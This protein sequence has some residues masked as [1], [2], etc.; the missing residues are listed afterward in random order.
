MKFLLAIAAYLVIGI[1]LCMGM[2]LG[3]A[4]GSWWLLVVSLVA[5]VVGFG[6][7]GCLPSKSS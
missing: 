6:K 3:M 7:I 1:L 5:Y 4:K 2:Y